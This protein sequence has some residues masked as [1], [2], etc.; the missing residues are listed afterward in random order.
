MREKKIF[1]INGCF[2]V[3]RYIKGGRKL[4]L[5]TQLN[6]EPVLAKSWNFNI[7]VQ[8][9]CSYFRYTGRLFLGCAVLLAHG[10]IIRALWQT[11][12]ERLSYRK[13]YIEEFVWG[14]SLF[15]LHALLSMS[16]SVAFFVFSLPLP[17][18][19]T[20]RMAPVKVHNIAIVRILCDVI[21]SK[22]SEI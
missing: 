4:H 6:K 21:M 7:F 22:R 5:W 19:R 15:W 3:S 18:C 9:W 14:T 20:C 1:C 12:K 16:F 8:I 2:I 17:N 10:N 13:T 11:K